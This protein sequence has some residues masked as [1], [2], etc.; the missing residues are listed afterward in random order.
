LVFRSL[1]I[2]KALSLNDTPSHAPKKV[3]TTVE[4]DLEEPSTSHGTQK[5][6]I[7][8]EISNPE[9]AHAQLSQLKRVLHSYDI[10]AVHPT[11]DKAFQYACVNMDVDII[12]LNLSTRLRFKLRHDLIAKAMDR[13]VAFEIPYS[14]FFTS[15]SNKRQQFLANA[16]ALVQGTK[17]SAI[18]CS[19]MAETAYDLRGPYDVANMATFFGM[20]EEQAY[21]SLSKTPMKAFEQRRR[22]KAFKQKMQVEHHSVAQKKF[23]ATRPVAEQEASVGQKRIDRLF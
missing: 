12:S 17:G 22:K 20:S 14:M 8:I 11:T 4:G 10:I 2:A 3:K 19:S 15:N 16:R 21:D 13:G 5:T 18:I 7:S 23:D 6:R 9:N 1:D